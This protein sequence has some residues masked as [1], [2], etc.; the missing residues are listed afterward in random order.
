MPGTSSSPA[1]LKVDVN[2]K[3]G[4]PYGLF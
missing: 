4:K 1:F 3:T 2:L